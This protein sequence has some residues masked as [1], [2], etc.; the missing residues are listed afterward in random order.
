MNIEIRNSV[1][2]GSSG[3]DYLSQTGFGIFK[4]RKCVGVC[5][6]VCVRMHTGVGGRDGKKKEKRDML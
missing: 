6:G 1:M 5:M 3:I 4:I 2:L